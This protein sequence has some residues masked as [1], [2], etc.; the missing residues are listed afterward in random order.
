MLRQPT[1]RFSGLLPGAGWP[2]VRPQVCLPTLCARRGS[3]CLDPALLEPPVCEGGETQGRPQMEV[4]ICS[5]NHV[6]PD[7]PRLGFGLSSPRSK[8]KP[9]MWTTDFQLISAAGFC[10]PTNHQVM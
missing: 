2:A 7:E 4:R 6:T 8:D 5:L 9:A 3:L 1:A 10:L